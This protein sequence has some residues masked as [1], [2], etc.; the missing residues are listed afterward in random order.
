MTVL[1]DLARKIWL[2]SWRGRG[3]KLFGK[4]L[5]KVV[6]KF[7]VGKGVEGISKIVLEEVGEGVMY[8]LGKW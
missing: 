1:E 7:T 4:R 5:E 6:M 8:W 2:G 3:R